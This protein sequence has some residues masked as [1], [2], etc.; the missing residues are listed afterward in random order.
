MVVSLPFIPFVLT[1]CTLLNRNRSRLAHPFTFKDDELLLRLFK[2]VQNMQ[3]HLTLLN[4][5]PLARSPGGILRD[6]PAFLSGKIKAG[7][8]IVAVFSS[9]KDT[10]VVLHGMHPSTCIMMHACHVNASILCGQM[11]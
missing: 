9:D 11:Y 1:L 3:V 2:M 7:D 4:P 5:N 10:P 8:K 6:S